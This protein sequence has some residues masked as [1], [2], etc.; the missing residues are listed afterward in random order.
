M[1]LFFRV[2]VK[3]QEESESG[4]KNLKK[5]LGSNRPFGGFDHY[6]QPH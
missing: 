1:C 5:I 6:D 4:P 3:L 2:R